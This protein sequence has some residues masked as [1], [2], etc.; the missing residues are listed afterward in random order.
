MAE[1]CTC[2][3][4]RRKASWL[5]VGLSR[6]SRNSCATRGKRRLKTAKQSAQEAQKAG[7]ELRTAEARPRPPRD[8]GTCQ[9]RWKGQTT[10]LNHGLAHTGQRSPGRACEAN[11]CNADCSKREGATKKPAN[12]LVPADA[13]ATGHAPHG[14][15]EAPAKSRKVGFFQ[16]LGPPP[17]IKRREACNPTACVATRTTASRLAWIAPRGLP[18][19]GWLTKQRPGRDAR[20]RGQRGERTGKCKHGAGVSGANPRSQGAADPLPA[21]AWG[22]EPRCRS[23]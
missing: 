19:R 2:C 13:P 17:L 4:S 12:H 1:C 11:S 9:A 22:R 8:R 3:G 6:W 5:W 20:D 16:E 10:R 7:T 23:G 14:T 18:R 21:A 15:G